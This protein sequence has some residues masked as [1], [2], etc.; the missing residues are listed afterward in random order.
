M[1]DKHAQKL[2]EDTG[3]SLI[4]VY[5]DLQV[6]FEKKYGK[7]TVVLIEIGSFFEVYGVDNDEEKIGKPKE[8]AEILNLQ[9]TRKNKSIQKNDAKNP[10]LAGFPVA[11][12][13]RYIGRLTEENKYTII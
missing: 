7:N 3:R 10:L 12:F 11:T 13:E 6:H 9:L 5:L 1:V 8:I 4:E 2:L